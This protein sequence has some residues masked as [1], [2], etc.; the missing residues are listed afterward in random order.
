[1]TED[2]VP[3]SSLDDITLSDQK[4]LSVVGRDL[5]SIPPV[6][7]EKYGGE[8]LSLDFSWNNISQVRNIEKFVNLKTL[9]LDNNN[10][11]SLEGSGIQDLK[12]LET[13]WLNNN[14]ITDLD[15]LITL[16]EKLPNLKY[17]S[18][19]KNP[20]CPNEFTGNDR[21]DYQMYRYYVIY[22]LKN[23]KFLDAQPVTTEE[24][25]L[26][27]KKGRFS[28]VVKIEPTKAA[29]A[30]NDTQE[31]APPQPQEISNPKEGT[32]ASFFGYSRHSYS[33]KHS[34]GN[35]FITNSEL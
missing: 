19:L 6:L 32:H 29:P 27:Q 3:G 1:M 12:S 14:N 33:G 11:E 26:A 20:A 2:A 10:L 16:L 15:A 31:Q 18:L 34:E 24:R 21:E 8:A 9:V 28:K 25:K 17:L 30:S 22:R 13:L 7:Q 23:L 35:R 5:S 4:Q